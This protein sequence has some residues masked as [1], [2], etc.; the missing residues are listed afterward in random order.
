MNTINIKDAEPLKNP[1]GVNVKRIYDT[2]HAQVVHIELRPGEQLKPHIT[3][4]DVFF[5]VLEG[6]GVVDIGD[7]TQTV[8]ADTLIDSPKGIPH[9]WYNKSNRILRIL[10]GKVPRPVSKTRVL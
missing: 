1:H 4:V 6:E 9:C 7:E 5:Y 3:P 2:E 10:V 8:S